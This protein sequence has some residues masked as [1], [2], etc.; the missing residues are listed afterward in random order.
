MGD[1]RVQE[2]DNPLVRRLNAVA[3]LNAEAGTALG[4][5][6]RPP[7]GPV[8]GGSATVLP[9]PPVPLAMEE[10][11][12]P[13]KEQAELERLWAEDPSNPAN[14]TQPS[15][16]YDSIPAPPADHPLF[17]FTP[18]SPVTP[19]AGQH[20]LSV[21]DMLPLSED[22]KRQVRIWTFEGAA[23]KV[24]LDAANRLDEMQITFGL[25][26]K[27]EDA[28]ALQGPGEESGVH[29]QVESGEPGVP[30]VADAAV[31][32]SQPGSSARPKSKVSRK[33][34]RNRTKP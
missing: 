6:S 32:R 4:G 14:R 11:P 25:A 20:Y 17:R 16:V 10:A 5:G 8:Q 30:S 27:K 15:Q 24:M 12:L 33:R 7:R 29:S 18:L 22:Q 1:P 19:L 21:I 13:P 31:E 3:A 28:S 2:R 23:Q 34:A 26:P 9:P